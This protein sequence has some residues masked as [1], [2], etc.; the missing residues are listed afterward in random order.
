MNLSSTT[1]LVFATALLA[2]A[3]GTHTTSSEVSFDDKVHTVVVELA[4]GSVTVRGDDSRG[5]A[6]AG[7]SSW[8]GA[9]GRGP[10]MDAWVHDGTMYVVPTCPRSADDCRMDLAVVAPAVADI[11]IAVGDGDVSIERVAGRIDATVTGGDVMLRSVTGDISVEAQRGDI[12]GINLTSL[13]TDVSTETGE[14]ELQFSAA[15]NQIAATSITGNIDMTMPMGQYDVFADSV[16][17]D[18]VVDVEHGGEGSPAL[19][20]RSREGQVR[21]HY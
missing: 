21:I 6:V 18:V 14:I 7:E 16:L 13:N 9:A 8:D 20:V 4:A 10:A 15:M 19:F 11:V 17:R 3:C 1:S 2:G 5:A 12:H